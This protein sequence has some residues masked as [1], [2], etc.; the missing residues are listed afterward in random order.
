MKAERIPSLGREGCPPP[1]LPGAPQLLVSPAPSLPR[2]QP[3]AGT[4]LPPGLA[5]AGLR[6]EPAFPAQSA[7]CAAAPC[8]AERWE[9][10]R[11]SRC[12]LAPGGATL[13]YFFPP[14]IGTFLLSFIA[15]PPSPRDQEHIQIF[16]IYSDTSPRSSGDEEPY[17]GDVF[18][19]KSQRD[20]S[21]PE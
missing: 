14:L 18:L 6:E 12:S 1:A 15:L 8:R 11:L 21:D 7:G 9:R 2:S 19:V 10:G 17:A 20:S 13:K 5:A 4:A 16:T 3:G